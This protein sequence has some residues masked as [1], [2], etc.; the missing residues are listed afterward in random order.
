MLRQHNGACA[1]YGAENRDKFVREVRKDGFI[2]KYR[3]FFRHS[4]LIPT[5]FELKPIW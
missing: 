3:P 1:G 4:S 5:G 2:V